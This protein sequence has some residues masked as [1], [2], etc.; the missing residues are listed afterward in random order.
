MQAAVTKIQNK[1]QRHR[2]GKHVLC[3]AFYVV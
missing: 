2:D 1:K 3:S